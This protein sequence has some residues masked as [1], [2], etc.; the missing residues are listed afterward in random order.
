MEKISFDADQLRSQFN[1]AITRIHKLEEEN[2]TLAHMNDMYQ[3]EI[4]QKTE[5]LQKSTHDYATLKTQYEELLMRVTELHIEN[6]SIHSSSQ[7]S[8]SSTPSPQLNSALIER[9]E[10]DEDL[11]LNLREKIEKLSKKKF[12][13]KR[14]LNDSNFRISQ[15]ENTIKQLKTSKNEI[16]N[17]TFSTFMEMV[18]P[19]VENIKFNT[20]AITSNQEYASFSYS[21]LLEATHSLIRKLKTTNS[22]ANDVYKQK[23]QKLKLKYK[24]VLNKCQMLAQNVANNQ[25]LLDNAIIEQGKK[26][27]KSRLDEEINRMHHF[28]VNYEKQCNTLDIF[29]SKH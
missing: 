10:R 22:N 28:L 4:S 29:P 7:S 25:T 20:N 15:L 16:W 8:Q 13:Y 26:R 1:N 24:K 27:Q 9:R 11:I 23:Y 5:A 6:Q 18:S 21:Y 19:Y 12:E 2:L 14:Q 17:S 3:E